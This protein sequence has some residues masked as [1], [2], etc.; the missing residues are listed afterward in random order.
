MRIAVHSMS[1]LCPALILGTLASATAR[2][3][4]PEPA[5][6]VFRNG[7][8][9]TVD[10]KRSWAEAARASIA[11]MSGANGAGQSGGASTSS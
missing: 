1:R 10:A 8:I 9:Y 4:P 3:A 7:G 5:D 11:R 2:A 6:V